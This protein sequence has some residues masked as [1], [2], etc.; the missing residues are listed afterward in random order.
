MNQLA[1]R[2]FEGHVVDLACASLPPHL[3]YGVFDLAKFGQPVRESKGA[4]TLLRAP[5]QNS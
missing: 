3:R 2:F 1:Q 5:D 4:L